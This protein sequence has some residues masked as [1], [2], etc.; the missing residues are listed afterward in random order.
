MSAADP[1]T[2]LDAYVRVPRLAGLWLSPD[3]R[4]LVVG[5]G[6]PD[7]DN[8]RYSTAL[9]QVDPAGEQPARRLTRSVKGESAAAFTPDGDLLFTSAR[10]GHDG[11]D[12]KDAKAALWLL[13]A[14]GGDA[15]VIAKLP[16]GVHGVQAGPD[17]TLVAGSAVL[18]SGD[19][20]GRERRKKAGVSAIL[21]EGYPVR[22]WDHD[23][24]PDRPRL[25][26]GSLPDPELTDVS[27]HAGRALDTEG[28]WELTPD[29]RSVVATWLVSEGGGSERSTV[30]VIDLASGE[31]RQIAGDD[32]NGYNSPRVSPD[33]SRVAML[34]RRKSSADDPGDIWLALVP[35][36]GGPVK[37]L[38][39][40]WDRW[41]HS[42]RWTADGAALVVAADDNGRSPLW[43]VDAATGAVTRLTD[44][45]GVYTDPRMSP[46]GRYVYALRS[47]VSSAPHPVRVSLSTYEI[48]L[49]P[50]PAPTLD[51]PGRLEEVTAQ[52]ADGSPLRAWLALP[53]GT[54]EPAPL[55]LWIHGGPLSSYNTWSWR[56]NPW[57]LVAR[58]Y[59]VL[60]PDPALSTGYGLDFIKR[61]WG[62]WGDKPY[63]DLMT[64]TDA[65]LERP[66][67][68]A[69]RTAA[70]GGSFGGYM[71]NWVA[72]HTDRF[73]AIVTHASLWALDQMMTT[74]DLAFYWLRE[75]TPER[76]AEHSP[77]RFADAVTTPMLVIH[78]DK[79]YRVPIGEGLRL[80]WDL[81]LRS[82]GRHKFLYYPDENHWILK[83]GNAKVWY[84]TVLAFLGHHVLG[85][86]WQR[87]ELLG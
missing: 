46:D 83:P 30:V 72:G 22:Y 11:D 73:D 12:D 85:E 53:P 62:T 8:A 3:G 15:R 79:D 42:P 76:L 2:D 13:P 16:G 38:A 70:M 37:A 51:V 59:A 40:D 50:S 19:D 69:T 82:E 44:D 47:T 66:D 9:W 24:G 25:F 74:T 49:L 48:E 33:G 35:V 71:A 61:G 23:L 75:L 18:P 55:V 60:M 41:P 6:T 67:L 58:G 80:W 68:D 14:A 20:A 56:W 87:P 29:G 45:D 54:G 78:G 52:A 27:G 57:L 63:T 65:A 77:N 1:F 4:R 26:A 64:I 86:K 28:D 84:E 5:V 34:V 32:A 43:R 21:H 36:A 10:P 39:A 31:R 81:L 7:K 17:G